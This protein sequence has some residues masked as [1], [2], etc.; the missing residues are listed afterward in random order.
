MYAHHSHYVI[1]ARVSSKFILCFDYDS[2]YDFDL[3]DFCNID[4]SC[5]LI[6][7][8]LIL[9]ITTNDFHNIKYH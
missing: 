6:L 3:N 5:Q 1:T 4:F 2:D 8:L 7:K 9:K